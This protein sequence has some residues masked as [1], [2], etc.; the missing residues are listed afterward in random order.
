MYRRIHC[1]DV[2]VEG[3]VVIEAGEAAPEITLRPIKKSDIDFLLEQ[4]SRKAAHFVR[5]REEMEILLGTPPI[6]S[7][8]ARNFIVL[9]GGEPAG[10]AFTHWHRR[11]GQAYVRER[12]GEPWAVIEGLRR[13]ARER[14]L[15]G[16]GMAFGAWEEDMVEEL[17]RRGIPIGWHH[18]GGTVKILNPWRF[19]DKIRPLL[20]ARVG[21]EAAR[22]IKVE[23]SVDDLTV[24]L[25][26]ESLR[27]KGQAIAQ[28][29]FGTP[30]REERSWFPARGRLRE[31][32]ERGLP[33]ARP[34]YEL[35]YV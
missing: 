24:R 6:D 27:V 18:G 16:I 31:V 35:N 12:A 11:R 13:F 5:S 8:P 26:E 21:E 1:A 28:L 22:E 2:G 3:R 9:K 23:G 15:K 14:G 10:Y 7:G 33:V 25:G 29:F 4:Y 32:L 19:L 34:L 20:A 17:E 30:G